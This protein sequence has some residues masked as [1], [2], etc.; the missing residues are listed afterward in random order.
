MRSMKLKLGSRVL[1][2]S[3]FDEKTG[4]LVRLTDDEG[5]DR[6][7]RFYDRWKYKRRMAPFS[8]SPETVD[9]SITDKCDFGCKYCYMDSRPRRKHAAPDLMS[10]IITGFT[11]PPYMVALGGGEPTQ[12]PDLPDILREIKRLG[13]VPNYTTAGHHM[14]DEIIRVTNE[15]C[16]GVAMTYHAF[17]GLDWFIEH[18]KAIRD[19]V[20]CQVNVHLIADKDCAQNLVDLTK[21]QSKIGT[22]NLILLAYYPD[23]G[24]ASLKSLM[25]RTAYTKLLPEAIGYAKSSSMKIAYSEGLLPYFLS[26]PELGISTKYSLRSEGY[27][28]CYFDPSG[29]ISHSSFSKP[30]GDEPTVWETSSQ[31]LWEDL[32]FFGGEPGGAACYGCS[33]RAVCSTPN[34]FSY[35]SCAYAG[36]NSLPLVNGDEE[37][38]F[39]SKSVFDRINEDEE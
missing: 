39:A 33:H 34:E 25:T 19:R 22:L 15:V 13:S 17:K 21:A 38:K 6:N 32:Y 10:K 18:Y 20:S 16:G 37:L 8:P 12:N 2:S 26:R 29:R 14:T 11:Q 3:T 30:K 35:L 23:V 4:A 24:R 27:F 7:Y 9:V 36:H 1:Y 5:E 28:S 31:K